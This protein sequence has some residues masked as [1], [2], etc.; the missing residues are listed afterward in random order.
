MSENVPKEQQ[1]NR[2]VNGLYTQLR[3]KEAV[4]KGDRRCKN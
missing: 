1:E 4:V 2:K 3:V